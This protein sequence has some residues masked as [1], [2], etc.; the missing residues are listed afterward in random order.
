MNPEE[1]LCLLELGHSWWQEKMYCLRA[2]CDDMEGLE[3]SAQCHQCTQRTQSS[4]FN[5]LLLK[6]ITACITFCVSTSV[7]QVL[8]TSQCWQVCSFITNWMVSCRVFQGFVLFASISVLKGFD[9]HASNCSVMF[10][11]CVC[12]R[13]WHSVSFIG[14]QKTKTGFIN[15][16]MMK[17]FPKAFRAPALLA[18][19]GH[20]DKNPMCP[21]L[22]VLY[23]S[24][25]RQEESPA[26]SSLRIKGPH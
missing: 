5:S 15:P 11:I 13:V 9:F 19:G 17:I 6:F 24:H 18:A 3:S 25:T 21:P 22:R 20:R 4:S 7:W 23:H 8:Q 2:G 1:L 14:G 12:V 16:E 10:S 26:D